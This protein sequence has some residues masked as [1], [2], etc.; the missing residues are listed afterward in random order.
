VR[1]D[2]EEA[3]RDKIPGIVGE[4]DADNRTVFFRHELLQGDGQI[5]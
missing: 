2:E 3:R 5:F 1:P 4:A